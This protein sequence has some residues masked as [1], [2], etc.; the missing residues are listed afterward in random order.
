MRDRSVGRRRQEY[1]PVRLLRQFGFAATG[2]QPPPPRPFRRSRGERKHIYH[3]VRYEMP[4]DVMKRPVSCRLRISRLAGHGTHRAARASRSAY[5]RRQCHRHARAFATLHRRVICRRLCCTLAR[6]S[7]LMFL[8]RHQRSLIFGGKYYNTHIAAAMPRAY[9]S[10]ACYHGLSARPFQQLGTFTGRLLP[11]APLDGRGSIHIRRPSSAEVAP[12]FR[13]S[14]C[15]SR[16]RS[17]THY[18]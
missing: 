2:A 4:Y 16:S 17:R 14:R 15:L 10:L 1:R 18:T 12:H 9:L 6:R 7:G 8:Y 13:Q 3:T 11:R 5:L